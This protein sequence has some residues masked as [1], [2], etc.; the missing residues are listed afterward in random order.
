VLYK[1]IVLE[2]LQQYPKLNQQLTSS[3]ALLST[4]EQKAMELRETHLS[5]LAELTQNEPKVSVDLLKAQAGEIAI[6]QLKEEL[7]HLES[8]LN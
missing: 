1:T 5:I 6:E 2:L 4:M 7:Q 3:K 8:E